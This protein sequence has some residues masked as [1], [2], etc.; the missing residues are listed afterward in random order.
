MVGLHVLKQLMYYDFKFGIA[1]DYGWVP[2]DVEFPQN[3]GFAK[4]V[5]HY[6]ISTI[7][8]FFSFINVYIFLHF[9]IRN[10]T[11]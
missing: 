4:R 3:V 5:K 10:T 7:H 6:E 8:N 9:V 1:L 11:C 2:Y